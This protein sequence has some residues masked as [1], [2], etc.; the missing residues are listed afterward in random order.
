[1]MTAAKR[2]TYEKDG[3]VVKVGQQ[4]CMRR[5]ALKLSQKELAEK[6]EVNPSVISRLEQGLVM[7]SED[8]LLRIVR[9]LDAKITVTI[10]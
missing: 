7:V 8:V 10:G 6:V 1:M 5:K 4:V 9:E 3:L 2:K